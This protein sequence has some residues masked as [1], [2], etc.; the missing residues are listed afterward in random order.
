MALLT[1]LDTERAVRFQADAAHRIATAA[2]TGETVQHPIHG[3][4][5]GGAWSDADAHGMAAPALD[6]TLNPTFPTRATFPLPTRTNRN[7]HW[8]PVI[9]GGKLGLVMATDI[10]TR[11]TSY[12][13]VNFSDVATSTATTQDAPAPAWVNG[14][15]NYQEINQRDVL[16]TAVA[17]DDLY[18]LAANTIANPTQYAF[19]ITVMDKDTGARRT[20]GY[21]QAIYLRGTSDPTPAPAT[22]GA[23]TSGRD[24][25]RG[26]AVS[27]ATAYLSYASGVIRRYNRLTWAVDAARDITLPPG[28]IDATYRHPSGRLF[29]EGNFLYILTANGSS[30]VGVLAYNLTTDEFSPEHGLTAVGLTTLSLASVLG[31]QTLWGFRVASDSVGTY[32]QLYYNGISPATTL[33]NRWFS[34]DWWISYRLART[35]LTL[36]RSDNLPPVVIDGLPALSTNDSEFIQAIYQAFLR[37]DT[38][39]D[40]K[41][42][43]YNQALNAL[44]MTIDGA[45][46][47]GLTFSAAPSGDNIDVNW[48]VV[49]GVSSPSNRRGSF[50]LD[51]VLRSALDSYPTSFIARRSGS[52]AR[53]N[54]TI[55]VSGRPAVSGQI[56]LAWLLSGSTPVNTGTAS[57]GTANDAARSDHDH[58]INVTPGGG[59]GANLS[60]SVPP[61]IAAA[62]SAGTGD[63]ASRD[64]HTH[65]GVQLAGSTATPVNTPGTASVGTATVA[66]RPITTMG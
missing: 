15:H 61:A 27:G 11:L 34:E 23:P 59:D 51:D 54:I 24:Q 28:A 45:S 60:S 56:D 20:T 64:D 32:I 8:A 35:N 41:R 9:D 17:G 44:G 49:G 57:A 1:E 14:T 21:R 58:G 55:G 22:T 39:G 5:I 4:V 25:P 6:R 65:A 31:S 52:T 47:P 26:I 50:R 53:I 46:L 10:G 19:Y 18:V 7:R 40:G 2:N 38:E 42:I 43:F 37:G 3:N 13:R 12:A 62:G 29:I 36:F 63:E 33:T 30:D 16:Q 48:E 66:A